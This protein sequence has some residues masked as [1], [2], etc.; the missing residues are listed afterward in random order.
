EWGSLMPGGKSW[1]VCLYS[2]FSNYQVWCKNFHTFRRARRFMKKN[3]RRNEVFYCATIS[4]E[5]NSSFFTYY[6]NGRLVIP[7]EKPWVLSRREALRLREDGDGRG[8]RS[9]PE[10]D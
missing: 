7:W 1:E 5:E 9:R 10:K 2:D 6:W 3:L 8:E 4:K